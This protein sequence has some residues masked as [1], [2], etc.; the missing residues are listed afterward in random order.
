MGL[1]TLARSDSPIHLLLLKSSAPMALIHAPAGDAHDHRFI[2]LSIT[3]WRQ[4]RHTPIMTPITLPNLRRFGS[5]GNKHVNR[6]ACHRITTPRLEKLDLDFFEYHMVSMP[7][8]VV[9]RWRT[10]CVALTRTAGARIL[11]GWE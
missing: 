6:G 5:R 10:P 9:Y 1:V 4:L 8:L 3:M 2:Y 7:S 11:S